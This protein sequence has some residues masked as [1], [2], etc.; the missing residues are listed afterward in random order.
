VL[1][2][3]SFLP[4]RGFTVG[5]GPAAATT[6]TPRPAPHP[7]LPRLPDVSPPRHTTVNTP[8]VYRTRAHCRTCIGSEQTPRLRDRCCTHP[9]GWMV[10]AGATPRWTIP[11]LRLLP[12]NTLYRSEPDRDVRVQSTPKLTVGWTG[13]FGTTTAANHHTTPGCTGCSICVPTSTHAFVHHSTHRSRV[14]TVYLPAW[15]VVSSLTRFGPVLTPRH[16]TAYWLGWWTPFNR[17]WCW[18]VCVV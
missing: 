7:T 5:G 9:R 3:G 16:T 1:Q 18:T 13:R 8:W 11:E 10:L 4:R 2:T 17:D 12:H 14:Y 6:A 15:P